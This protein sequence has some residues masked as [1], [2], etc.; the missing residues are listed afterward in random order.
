L[1]AHLK[2]APINLETKFLKELAEPKH[3]KK[4]FKKFIDT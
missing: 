1:Q 3:R 4:L 2:T